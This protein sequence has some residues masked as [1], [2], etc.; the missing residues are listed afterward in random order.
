MKDVRISD[1]IDADL[2]VVEIIR[3]Y[4]KGVKIN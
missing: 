1:I 3:K 2:S 4:H